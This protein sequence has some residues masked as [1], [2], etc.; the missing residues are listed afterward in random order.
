VKRRNERGI[1]GV[2]EL[3]NHHPDT[4]RPA[5][6]KAPAGLKRHIPESSRCAENSFASLLRDPRV[7]GKDPRDSRL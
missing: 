4:M 6:D 7:P 5:C 3:C 1:E 2:T